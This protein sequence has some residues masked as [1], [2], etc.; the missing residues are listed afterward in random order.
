M[1]EP[2]ISDI[3]YG[4]LRLYQPL[5]ADGPRVNVDTV[6][7]AH[8]AR[9]PARA[10][11]LEMGCAHGAISL[12]LARRMADSERRAPMLDAFDL[13]ETLVGMANRNAALNGLADRV[14]FFA[15]D[16]RRYRELCPSERY[17]AV[18]MNP[19]YD[20]PGRSRPS[21]DAAVAAAKHGSGCTFREVAEAAKYFLKNRGRFFLVMRANR[22]AEAMHI[23]HETKLEPKRLRAVHPKPNRKA[24]VVLL[25]AVRSGG[26]GLTI[27]PPLLIFGE[28]GRYTE[29][30]LAAYRTQREKRPCRS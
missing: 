14:R 17:D 28:D 10:R 11:V 30:L 21:A 1:G 29:G 7:L 20:E 22:C 23:L 4:A 5:E 8:F 16:L 6:L 3:L 9:F 25:E 18:I 19:P 24:S 15:F 12:I 27:E 26:G 2:E 13:N